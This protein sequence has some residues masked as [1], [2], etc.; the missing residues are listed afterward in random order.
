[1][2]FTSTWIHINPNSGG[3]LRWFAVVCG[4]LRWFSRFFNGARSYRRIIV[5][6]YGGGL[7]WFAV[8]CGGLRWF[9]VVCGGLW[10]FVVDCGGLSFS[11]TELKP[12][13]LPLSLQISTRSGADAVIIDAA[14][15]HNK[16][17]YSFSRIGHLVS[18]SS[19]LLFTLHWHGQTVYLPTLL[20][21]RMF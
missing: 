14:D 15:K 6:N 9:V 11:H 21:Y 12:L 19:R 20:S 4:G 7:W 13:F 10:W 8:V 1:M 3:G 2:L 17:T 16:D 18:S 5:P